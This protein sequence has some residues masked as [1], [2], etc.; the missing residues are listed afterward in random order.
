MR[1][2]IFIPTYNERDNV[3]PMCE[4]ILAL[5]LDADLVFMDD[6]S[7]DGTGAVLD[8]LAARHSRVR[9]LHR[10]SKAGIG[11]AHLDG[12]A[13]AYAQGYDR[14]VTLDCDFTH[15]P[16]LIPTFLARSDTATTVLGS[17]YLEGGSLPGWSLFRKS[18][19]NVGHLLTKTMLN[20]S[21][22]AT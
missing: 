16:A 3:Q 14:L 12:I 22:D 4:Q 18:M 7:A 6:N 11:S 10:P 19:T 20:L 17:R 1:V 13:Y 8:A 9:V 21:Q 15:S 2:L 5:G